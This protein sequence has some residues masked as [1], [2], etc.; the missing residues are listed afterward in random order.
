[1]FEPQELE[2]IQAETRRLILQKDRPKYTGGVNWLGH[3][4]RDGRNAYIDY[5]L[6]DGATMEELRKERTTEPSIRSHFQSLKTRFGLP[7]V[8]TEEGKYRFDRAILGIDIDADAA[9][10]DFEGTDSDR[11][12]QVIRQ[13]RER[14]GQKKFRDQLRLRYG[15]QCQ[16]TGCKITELLEA[17]HIKDYRG[18]DDNEV[19]NGLLLRSDIHT[20]FDLRLIGI[21]PDTLEVHL[22]KRLIGSEY[23]QLEGVKLQC[24]NG[25]EPATNALESR[26]KL[27]LEFA[28]TSDSS[29]EHI[30]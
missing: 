4:S 7:V 16:L 19:R 28:D 8:R 9:S 21:H 12:E 1:M 11:R 30:N 10:D 2:R 14:R 25:N 17:A 18:T 26:F 27:F 5:M 22:H 24:E 6:L 20:L 3:G 29:T 15:D 13:I 23:S